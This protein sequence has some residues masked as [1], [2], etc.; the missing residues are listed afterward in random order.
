MRTRS[1]PL[2][3]RMCVPHMPTQSR[4]H[5]TQPTEVLRKP[6]HLWCGCLIPRSKSRSILRWQ[7]WVPCHGLRGHGGYWPMRNNEHLPPII[8]WPP[9]IATSKFHPQQDSSSSRFSW[10]AFDKVHH[11]CVS[12]V[13]ERGRARS[14]Y[15]HIQCV[16][17]LQII[18]V[19]TMSNGRLSRL[20]VPSFEKR[21]RSS[22][23]SAFD[24]AIWIHRPGR[25]RF[26][27]NVRRRIAW[28]YHSA[29]HRSC[30]W[31]RPLKKWALSFTSGATAL[32]G[33]LHP[34]ARIAIDGIGILLGTDGASLI[35]LIRV[36]A[37]ATPRR[38]TQGVS[39]VFWRAEPDRPAVSP[40]EVR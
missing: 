5:G 14:V 22:L 11:L 7:E 40:L 23:V 20:S 30:E 36:V 26:D 24:R 28:Q 18:Y 1:R 2:P 39:L 27:N 6:C 12:V 29:C 19:N 25:P 32:A 4:G 16:V 15:L 3:E 9:Q 38:L 21:V 33:R 17:S 37:N 10:N 34:Q 8:S 35:G 31:F 13:S